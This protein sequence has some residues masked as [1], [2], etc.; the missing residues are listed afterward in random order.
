MRVHVDERPRIESTNTSSTAR[1]FAA[2]G[3]FA[4]QRSRPASASSFFGE[5]AMMSN[6]NFGVRFYCPFAREGATRGSSSS[7]LR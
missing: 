6:G 4:F 1:C 7:I 5:F 2:S 3:Y